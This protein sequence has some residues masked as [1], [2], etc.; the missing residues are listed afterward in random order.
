MENAV[1]M[2]TWQKWSHHADKHAEVISDSQKLG[3][4]KTKSALCV[5]SSSTV[6]QHI[7]KPNS[8]VHSPE[9]IE[10]TFFVKLLDSIGLYTEAQSKNRKASQ[11]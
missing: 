5:G 11:T 4:R 8:F 2:K 3:V 1:F 7:K 10:N 9:S 6:S